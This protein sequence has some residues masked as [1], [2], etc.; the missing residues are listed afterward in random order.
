MN[1]KKLFA[2]GSLSLALLGGA[3]W[4]ARTMKAHP[5]AAA[6]STMSLCLRQGTEYRYQLDWRTS[7]RA[8]VLAGASPDEAGDATLAGGKSHI[9]GTLVLRALQ[10]SDAGATI[11]LS[12]ASL[13]AADL[14]IAGNDG[15]GH[16]AP[17]D[18]A[19]KT[20]EAGRA[21]VEIDRRGGLTAI[22]FRADEAP[23]FRDVAR[24]LLGDLRFELASG[25]ERAWTTRERTVHGLAKNR[26]EVRDDGTI[27]RTR[28]AYVELRS[29]RPE[30][31]ARFPPTVTGDATLRLDAEGALASI[32]M[33]DDVV[34][35][36]S[37]ARAAE[38]E[39][40]VSLSATLTGTA[41]FDAP[42]KVALEGLDHV[43]PDEEDARPRGDRDAALARGVTPAG[44]EALLA[45]YASSGAL[46]RGMIAKTAAYLRTH[47]EVCES[48]AQLFAQPDTAPKAR[49]LA[50]DLLTAAGSP[51]AQAAMRA[52]LD[53]DAA[54]SD[55]ASYRMLV[56]RFSLVR[57]PTAASLAYVDGLAA[58]AAA[59]GDAS[60]ARASTAALGAMSG[61]M[62]RD[63]DAAADP[64]A[65]R[66]VAELGRG[67]TPEDRAA[68]VTAVG[69]MQR[70]EDAPALVA[71]AGDESALIR[72]RVATALRSATDMDAR[73]ALLDLLGDDDSGVALAA[74][75]SYVTAARAA[76]D[77]EA[78]AARIADGST[79]SAANSALAAALGHRLGDGPAASD[80][81]RAI[82]A[83]APE[84]SALAARV[85]AM[86]DA[87]RASL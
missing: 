69:N 8:R 72:A 32:A 79:H 56:Q 44:I 55:P 37:P 39:I 80:A 25:S 12:L 50:M 48:V 85:R 20:L 74:A 4:S 59:S 6:R 10:A 52:A 41:T 29:V 15:A 23:M 26:Y 7:L 71:L 86:L 63:G 65:E 13:T 76:A 19:K 22:H 73:G 27:A 47:P 35:R 51:T 11:E 83:R 31:L 64:V 66:L 3:V 77:L 53:S 5:A 28:E 14:E 18:I 2:V 46:P 58:S 17:V 43:A 36:R 75:G 54:K 82:L 45:G 62:L 81:L 78:L 84:G 87:L 33:R 38:L 16:A 24:A 60:T 9:E 42:A 61:A 68:I 57:S 49:E 40:H 30:A 70:P 1:T 21:T 34:L 67:D